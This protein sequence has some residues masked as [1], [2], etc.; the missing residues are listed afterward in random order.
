MRSSSTGMFN[1][2][3]FCSL[4][5]KENA[6]TCEPAA[7]RFC[8]QVLAGKFCQQPGKGKT[9]ELWGPRCLVSLPFSASRQGVSFYI[10]WKLQKCFLSVNE[11]LCSSFSK[12]NYWGQ[13][14]PSC[15]PEGQ[16]PDH[17][18]VFSFLHMSLSPCFS[19]ARSHVI[20]GEPFGSVCLP[21]IPSGQPKVAVVAGLWWEINLSEKLK[22]LLCSVKQISVVLF[23]LLCLIEF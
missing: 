1:T 18:I 17:S 12:D 7:C 23:P 4:L 2:W 20:Q 11:A 9:A 16:F 13:L 15:P 21:H 6:V 10:S 8:C 14:L 3:Q 5:P 19:T 22:Q